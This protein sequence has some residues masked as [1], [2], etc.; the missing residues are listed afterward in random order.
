MDDR[1]SPLIDPSLVMLAYRSGIFPMA[2]RRDDPDIFWVEPKR[3]GILPLDGFRCSHSLAR[4]LRRGRLRVTC[5][6]A[7]SQ[8]LAAC[9]A[10]RMAH[11]GDS[12]EDASGETWISHRIA[13]TY[14]KLHALG[15]AHSVECWQDGPDGAPVLVGGLYGVGFDRV[16]CGESM[17]S[18]VSEASKVALAWLVVALRMGGVELL[19]CQFITPHL[20]SLGAVEISQ[21]R[22]LSLLR[23]AQRGEEYETSHRSAELLSAQQSDQSSNSQLV[24][25]ASPPSASFP[26]GSTGG[27]V[28]TGVLALPE[29][30][31]ALAAALKSSGAS[32]SPGNFIAQS[33]TQ[34]S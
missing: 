3:R 21:K 8:V 31:G 13:G 14:E 22:Y 1:S 28:T 23:H 16:F 10:P 18:R 27:G 33:L 30:F 6:A 7:F 19:D 32:S 34:T 4:T 29:A 26:P 17:F 25:G 11:S 2:D 9:A 20:A 12:G 15:F 24:G 5:N